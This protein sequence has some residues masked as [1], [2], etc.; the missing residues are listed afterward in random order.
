MAAAWYNFIV[1]FLGVASLCLLL[2]SLVLLVIS[3][4]R[5]SRRQ[6][7]L[8]FWLMIGP[9]IY[10]GGMLTLFRFANRRYNNKMMPILTG[11]YQ[12]IANDTFRVTYEL[13]GDNTFLIKSPSLRDSGTWTI[14]P[15][16]YLIHFYH[17]DKTEFTRSGVKMTG[18]D[19]SLIFLNG[20]DTIEMTKLH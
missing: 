18:G 9:I 3:L 2:F 17:P 6:R 8:A 20:A 15:N 12:Y 16:A 11:T 1:G 7:K 5:K 10:L 19:P 14:D 4:V 13:K